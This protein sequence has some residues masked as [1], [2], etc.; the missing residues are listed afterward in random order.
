M[1]SSSSAAN[2][3]VS[4]LRSALNP[5]RA[6]VEP[7]AATA[8]PRSPSV[9]D[10]RRLFSNTRRRDETLSALPR[11]IEPAACTQRPHGGCS[12]LLRRLIVRN[13]RFDVRRGVAMQTANRNLSYHV[14]QLCL[15]CAGMRV[16]ERHTQS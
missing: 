7:L 6:V 13:I 2:A 16:A 8:N 3:G 5:R 15:G 12:T 14:A 10:T 1:R 4:A 11:R 9:H